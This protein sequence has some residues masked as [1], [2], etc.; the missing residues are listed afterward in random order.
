MSLGDSRI[1]SSAASV[2]EAAS[3][4]ETVVKMMTGTKIRAKIR[5]LRLFG[6]SLCSSLRRVGLLM[7][8]REKDVVAAAR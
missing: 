4:P 8:V 1:A 7:F 5:V 2:W 6:S 3:D